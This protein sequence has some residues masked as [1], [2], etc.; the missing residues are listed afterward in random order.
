MFDIILLF[1]SLCLVD[2]TMIHLSIA[3]YFLSLEYING[4]KIPVTYAT[5]HFHVF[6]IVQAPPK[7]HEQAIHRTTQRAQTAG[8]VLRVS[9]HLHF[10]QPYLQLLTSD[11]TEVTCYCCDM[12]HVS[13]R[14]VSSDPARLRTANNSE[15]LCFLRGRASGKHS[16]LEHLLKRPEPTEPI[17]TLNTRE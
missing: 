8:C 15:F 7:M 4:S 9:V 3:I 12:E 6:S 11:V 5:G 1:P 17:F 10:V 13:S 2:L 14:S 16:D